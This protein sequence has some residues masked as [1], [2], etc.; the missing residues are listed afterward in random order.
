MAKQDYSNLHDKTIFD[1]CSDKKTL[2]ELTAI[3]F[4]SKEECIRRYKEFPY[5]NGFALLD[6]A[7]MTSNKSLEKAVNEQFKE[8]FAKVFNE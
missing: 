1:F 8:D 2:E 5:A 4:I 7:E 3:E 6:Y